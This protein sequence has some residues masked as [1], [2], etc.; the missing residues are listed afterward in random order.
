MKKAEKQKTPTNL[1]RSAY[2]VDRCVHLMV[3]VSVPPPDMTFRACLADRKK[4]WRNGKEML[5]KVQNRG[6]E[7]E[8]P[9]D[10]SRNDK[11][12]IG[13]GQRNI[14]EK[15]S[16]KT[17]GKEGDIKRQKTRGILMVA[18]CEQSVCECV[19]QGCNIE[20]DNTA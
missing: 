8:S 12:R 19:T 17:E 3:C 18:L 1:I 14:K 4:A 10:R 6:H 2:S 7:D 9:K 11:G 5:A 20:R 15:L 16:L 13:K